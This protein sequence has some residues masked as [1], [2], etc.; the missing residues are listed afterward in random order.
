MSQYLKINEYEMSLI[1]EISAMSSFKPLTVRYVL[2]STFLRQLET[3]LAG[4]DIKIPFLGELHIEYNGENY[5]SGA[6]VADV[7]CTL[8][9]S[10]LFLKLIGEIHDGDSD[11]I[12]QISEKKIRSAIQKKLEE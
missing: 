11:I 7:V 8:K 10:D 3:L 9:P 12:W 6:Q 2:E 1:N 4:E 5:V